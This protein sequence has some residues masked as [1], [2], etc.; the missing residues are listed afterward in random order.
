MGPL[1][2]QCGPLLIQIVRNCNLSRARHL[3]LPNSDI[4]ASPVPVDQRLSFHLALLWSKPLALLPLSSDSDST[5]YTTSLLPR[6]R[7]KVLQL[8]SS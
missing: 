7:S 2:A 4:H 5:P 6:R 8:R 1:S 3:V